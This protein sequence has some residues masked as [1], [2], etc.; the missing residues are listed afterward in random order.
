MRIKKVN[1]TKEDKIHVEYEIVKSGNKEMKKMIEWTKYD[2]KNTA[3][4]SA[5]FKTYN[6]L[7]VA[8]EKWN[9]FQQWKIDKG[10]VR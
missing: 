10:Y 8:L 7:R 4:I 1:V 6:D 9:G 2:S 3:N 5:V